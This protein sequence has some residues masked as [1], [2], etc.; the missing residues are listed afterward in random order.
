[1]AVNKYVKFVRGS[2]L[3]FNGL[4]N[5]DSDTLYFI[6]D[7]DSGKGSLY[8]GDKLISGGVSDLSDFQNIL[9]EEISDKQLL[10][11]DETLEKWVNKSATEAIG[12]M[13][14][15]KD[16]SQGGAGLVP[17][18]GIN[19]QNLFL[20]GDGTWAAPSTSEGSVKT[21]NIYEAI[22]DNSSHAVQ[23]EALSAVVGNTALSTG[24]IGIVKVF[25]SEDKYQYTAYV[26]N[27]SQWA[28]MDGNYSPDSIYFEEDLV[29]TS[30]IGTITQKMI[31]DGGGS[32]SLEASNKNMLQVLSA[33]LAEEKDP[34]VSY[35]SVS[36]TTSGGS[37]EVGTTFT[38]P[39]ATLTILDVGNY[40]YGSTD[41]TNKYEADDTG[42]V[43]EAG[44][45]VLTQGTS[46]EKM[47]FTDLSK[48]DSLSIT[49]KGDSN[50]YQD[51]AVNFV[52]KANTIKYTNS[53]NKIPVTN[54]GNPVLDFKI[55]AEGTVSKDD[56][57][58]KFTGYRN[59][60]Y[61]SNTS[62]M[63]L[64]SPNIRGLGQKV[65]AGKKTLSLEVKENSRQVVIAV[66]SGYKVTRVEDTVAW[67]TDLSP[68]F[69]LTENI[70][71]EGANGYTSKNYN[72]YVYSPD[73]ALGKNTYNV[74]VV[75]E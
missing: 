52:F 27:G 3:V 65:Q 9:I 20:R 15:A 53:S 2:S 56:I 43:F 40:S 73:T 61:G 19:Q 7:S 64:N 59:I 62:A 47:N 39:T 51:T 32:A 68:Q 14:G 34:E 18:P 46:N 37:G 24:D 50:I 49:A 28:A 23:I 58:A 63:E 4:Q 10:V 66:P 41:G 8:L 42:V 13:V 12:I 31:D 55:P 71:V 30:P 25:I 72:V 70:L 6:T 22:A 67:N 74:T 11:Y 36:F 45:I 16:G 33:L 29:V 1:M 48:G 21:A 57:T 26:Y 5:K 17:A 60:F 75:T 38:L 44:N 69:I 35:P 54:L